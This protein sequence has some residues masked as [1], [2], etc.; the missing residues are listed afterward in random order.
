MSVE[1]AE[2]REL[3]GTP[4]GRGLS[5]VSDLNRLQ[6]QPAIV[7]PFLEAEEGCQ[8]VR[9]SPRH[10]KQLAREG[11]V[12]AHPRGNGPRKHW[13]FLASELYRWMAERVNSACDPGRDTQG[14]L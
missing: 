12:P 4:S 7:E 14:D 1:S 13:L 2:Y 11:K 5:E 3:D 6:L 8:I 9:L 10:L